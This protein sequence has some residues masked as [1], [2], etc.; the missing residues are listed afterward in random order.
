MY[1]PSM[2]VETWFAFV[3]TAGESWFTDQPEDAAL[4]AADGE[5]IFV[6]VGVPGRHL[7]GVVQA[8]E[9][10]TPEALGK[11]ADELAECFTVDPP[12]AE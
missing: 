7:G 1:A 4:H 8:D 2:S 12:A 5:P 9:N 10:L 6:R 3:D 11:C